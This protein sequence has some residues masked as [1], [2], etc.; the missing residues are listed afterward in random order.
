MLSCVL[1]EK[2]NMQ[3]VDREDPPIG[4]TDVRIST[5]TVGICGSD[6]H[7]FHRAEVAGFQVREPLALGHEACGRVI[8]VG[9][10]VTRL[11]VDD[12]V[13][14]NP[15]RTCGK[16]EF[17]L[18]G[19]ENLCPQILFMGSASHNPHIQG[20]FQERL[21]VSEA[22]CVRTNK[23][24]SFQA[25]AFAEPLSVALHTI[26]RAGNVFNKKLLIIGAGAIGLLCAMVARMAGAKFITI[27]DI[28][29]YPLAIAREI[30]VDLAV[31]ADEDAELIESWKEKGEYDI[32]IEASGTPIGL[33]TAVYS[34]NRG[35]RIVEVGIL[36]SGLIDI[37]YHVMFSREL[38]IAS[39]LRQN[40]V[41]DTAV[42]MIENGRIDVMPLLSGRFP[43]TDFAT[44]FELAE[45]REK[46]IKIQL[47]FD[48]E[49]SG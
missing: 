13:V 41:F 49:P 9:R 1:I 7:Y 38:E 19:K 23:E 35:A 45:D 30:G 40:L 43:I 18:S 34:A 31:N 17:C 42:E 2:N 44:A 33:K 25:L 39:V 12:V 29:K 8:E 4:T 14:V 20:A 11:Q 16:C 10:D 21:V 36:P 15:G 32:V 26:N 3:L 27:S 48:R 5:D 37:P 6:I 24:A 46:S 47:Y 28:H 22:Q